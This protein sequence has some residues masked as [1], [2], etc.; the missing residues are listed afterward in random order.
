MTD[1]IKYASAAI[2]ISAVLLFSIASINF[3]MAE[4]AIITMV[5][6]KWSA[7]KKFNKKIDKFYFLSY[8][9]CGIALLVFIVLQSSAT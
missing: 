8:L 3:F 1:E 6:L 7:V 5:C 9:L 2:L 4:V